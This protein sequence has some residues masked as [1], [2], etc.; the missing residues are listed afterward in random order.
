MIIDTH[1]HG[2]PQRF[3]DLT[4][5]RL[6][7][8]GQGMAPFDEG[9]YIRVLDMHGIDIGVLSNPG[10]MIEHTGDRKK[11]LEASQI[12]NDTFAGAHAKH[13][14]RFKAF[15]RPPMLDMD[16]AVR[17]LRRCFDELGMHGVVLSTNLAG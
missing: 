14:H 1:F 2:F 6:D 17:E 12:L 8:R 16:D 7:S 13:P 10:S 4:P 9:E 3:L 15:A 11:A 5:H